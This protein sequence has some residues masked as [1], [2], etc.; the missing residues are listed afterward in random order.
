LHEVL[1]VDHAELDVLQ[2][3]LDGGIDGRLQI[4]AQG[5]PVVGVHAQFDHPRSP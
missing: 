3:V 4:A 1:A 2:A 5:P